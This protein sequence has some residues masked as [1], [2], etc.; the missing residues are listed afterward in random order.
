[1]MLFYFIFLLLLSLASP[2]GYRYFHSRSVAL[3]L[4]S[5][6][7]LHHS[8]C[9]YLFV[10]LCFVASSLCPVDLIFLTTSFLFYFRIFA[11]YVL[12]VPFFFF[13]L[14]VL[15]FFLLLLSNE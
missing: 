2:D 14:F 12:F 10:Q 3:V 15:S 8:C 9:Y 13:V 1:M 11:F 5:C 4:A 7:R 6:H